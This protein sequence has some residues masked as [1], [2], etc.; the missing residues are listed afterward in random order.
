MADETTDA[1]PDPASGLPSISVG[2]PVTSDEVADALDEAA[3]EEI[4]PTVAEV[5]NAD[6]STQAAAAASRRMLD[7]LDDEW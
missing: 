1:A 4:A 5:V 3:D 2:H 6:E 7:A